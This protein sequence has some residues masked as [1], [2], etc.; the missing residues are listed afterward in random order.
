MKRA[1][2]PSCDEVLDAFAVEP[3]TGRATLERYLRDYPEYA[4]DLVD[5]ASELSREVVVKEGPLSTEDQALIHAAWKKHV[6]AAPKPVVEPFSVWSAMEVRKVA[7][8][9]EVPRQVLTAFRERAVLAA[10]VPKPFMERLA[11]A[12]ESSFDRLTAYLEA[13]GGLSLARSYKADSKPKTAPLV[14]FKQLLIDAGVPAEK[15][16]ELMADD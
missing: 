16:K 4:E 5:L 6:K 8:S 10:S 13:P 1:P 14:T 12:L 9:L 3:D 11:S 15:R 2:R 7:A